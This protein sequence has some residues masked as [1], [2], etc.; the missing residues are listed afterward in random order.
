MIAM[1][2]IDADAVLRSLPDD[3]PYKDSARR[4]LIQAPTVDAVQVMRCMDCESARE[5]TKHESIY[6]ADGVLICTNC[7]VSEDCRLPVWP[8]HFCGYG[9]EKDGG[10]EDIVETVP[11][12]RCENC[13]YWVS[14]KNECESW[15]WCKMLNR[16]MPPH[17]FCNLGERKDDDDAKE[18]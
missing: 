12:V 10:E 5:L 3:L 6:L 9:R 18:S 17:A 4:V 15:E 16:D 13:L 11:V 1:R 14:G 7:E 8:Q 2:L